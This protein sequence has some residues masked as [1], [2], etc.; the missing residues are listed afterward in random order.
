MRSNGELSAVISISNENPTISKVSSFYNIRN[1][2]LTEQIT[3]RGQ[4]A[5]LP[6]NNRSP[7]NEH[8]EDELEISVDVTYERL[9]RRSML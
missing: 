5:T 4:H 3:N 6:F 2:P 9:K 7:I 8:D 1:Q